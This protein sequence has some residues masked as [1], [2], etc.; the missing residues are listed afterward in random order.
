MSIVVRGIQKILGKLE[1]LIDIPV[2]TVTEELANE[3]K[4][5]IDS[6]YSSAFSP[7]NTDWQTTIERTT[8]GNKVVATGHDVG[9]LEFGTGINAIDPDEFAAYAPYDVSPGSWSEEHARQ[10]TEKKGW[11]YGG[12]YMKGTPPTRG[13]QQGLDHI[14]STAK[15]KAKGKVDQWIKGS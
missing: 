5:I 14:R 8:F 6:A 12:E 10:Y 3:A 15:I 13:M 9:F 4:G 2:N 1:R 11:F 7:G